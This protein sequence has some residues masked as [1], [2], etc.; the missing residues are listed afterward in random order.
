MS[1]TKLLS[2]VLGAVLVLGSGTGICAESGAKAGSEA[3]PAPASQPSAKKAAH[4][5][6]VYADQP[7]FTEQE[8]MRFAKLL[9]DF[10]K[11]CHAQGE[12]AHPA[13]RKGKADFVYSEAVAGW[14]RSHGWDDRRFFCVMGRSAAA[15][16]TIMAEEDKKKPAHYKDMPKVSQKELDLVRLHLGELL[17]AGSEESK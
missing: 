10:R 1:G 8:L 15:L 6:S 16:A 12:K 14:A 17:K 3:G 2:L 7:E 13:V 9:P 11:W 5:G 4:K